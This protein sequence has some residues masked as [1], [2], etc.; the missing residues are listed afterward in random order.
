MHRRISVV[1]TKV[2]RATRTASLSRSA[3][4]YNNMPPFILAKS[5]GD[6]IRM[7]GMYAF[8]MNTIEIFLK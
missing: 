6:N 4:D 2:S 1:I 8:I 5:R 7:K 3:S